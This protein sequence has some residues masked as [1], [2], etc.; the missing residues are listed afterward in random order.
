MTRKKICVFSAAAVVVFVVALAVVVD[1]TGLYRLED[2]NPYTL[3]KQL[4]GLAQ[5]VLLNALFIFL[6]VHQLKERKGKP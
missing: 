4:A 5:V 1:R 2:G 6:I 3:A